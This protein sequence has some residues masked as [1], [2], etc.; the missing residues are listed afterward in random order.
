MTTGFLYM[1]YAM[2]LS[3]NGAGVYA[4]IQLLSNNVPYLFAGMRGGR[5]VLGVEKIQGGYAG[6][7]SAYTVSTGTA[8]VHTVVA[9]YD[10]SAR[11]LSLV[12]VY[13]T[14]SIAITE[15]GSWD[16]TYTVPAADAPALL[17]GIRL[18]MGGYGGATLGETWLDEIRL[19]RSWQELFRLDPPVATNYAVGAANE[20][21]DGA[22][23]GGTYGVALWLRDDAGL[24]N[25][26]TTPNVDI[27]T[28]GG[29][30]VVTDQTFAVRT[31]GDGDH[32]I[33]PHFTIK[34]S[35]GEVILASIVFTNRPADGGAT[36]YAPLGNDFV[37][38]TVNSGEIPLGVYT[39]YVTA[40][41]NDEDRTGD[42]FVTTSVA[43][44]TFTVIQGPIIHYT[45]GSTND[46]IGTA[47]SVVESSTLSSNE[48]IWRDRAFEQRTDAGLNVNNDLQEF[49]VAADLNNLYFL[50]RMQDVNNF[51]APYLAIT[52]DTDQSGADSDGAAVGSAGGGMSFNGDDADTGLGDGYHTNG[53]AAL[54]Y[55]ERQIIVHNIDG[56]GQRIELYQGTNWYAPA[57]T[58]AS[59]TMWNA[60]DEV[61]EFTIA[62]EALGLGGTVTARFTVA[63]YQNAQIWANDGDSTTN[64]S[65]S[66]ALDT[67]ALHAYGYNHG[68]LNQNAYDQDIS[69]GDLDFFF[70][71]R[72]GN[73]G[74]LG[75]QIPSTPGVT[76]PTNDATLEAG[77]YVTF[78]WDAATDAD[79]AVTS[80]LLEIGTNSTLGGENATVDYRYNIRGNTNAYTVTGLGS[81]SGT[82]FFWRVRSRDRAGA[83]SASSPIRAFYLDQTDDDT[84]VPVPTLLYVGTNYMPGVSGIKT[85]I[86]DAEAA[87]RLVPVDIAIQWDDPSG[88]F[89]TN[90]PPY[91]STNIYSAQGRIVPNWD[92]TEV[93]GTTTNTYGYDKPFTNFWGW[94]GAT[95]VTTYHH[96]AFSLTNIDLS[97]TYYL[98]VSAEDED[99]E[100][101][102]DP[103]GGGDGDAIPRDHAVATNALL[104]FYVVDDDPHPPTASNLLLSGVS[105]AETNL[106]DQEIRNGLWSLYLE[107]EDAYSGMETSEASGM[108]PRYSMVN[109]LGETVHQ[110]RTW[111]SLSAL[112]ASAIR[113]GG[114]RIMD[115]VPYTNVALGEYQVLWTAYDRDNDRTNDRASRVNY[116]GLADGTNVFTVVDDDTTPP[117]EITNVQY[118]VPGLVWTNVNYF[119]VRWTEA[120]DDSGVTEY[121]ASTNWLVEP[122]LI[123]DGFPLPSFAEARSQSL[124]NTSFG[125]A[126]SGT[127]LPYL[128]TNVYGWGSFSSP[129]ARPVY[130]NGVAQDGS[131][132]MCLLIAEGENPGF[133]PRYAMAGQD[134]W[135]Y[136]SNQLPVSLTYF[137]GY[138]R[139][140]LSATGYAG[141][142]G[143]AYL[144]VVFM[145]QY[146]NA[147]LTVDNEYDDDHNGAPL[148]GVNA[149]DWTYTSISYTNGPASTAFIRFMVGIAQHYSKLAYTG[150]WDS[151]G[152][153]ISFGYA[154]MSI[155][156]NAGE[157]VLTNWLFAVDSD[158][159]RPAD[160]LK[161]PN[162]NFVTMLDQTPPPQV[163]DLSATNGPDETSEALLEWTPLAHAGNRA[164]DDTPLSPWRSYVLFYEECTN[165]PVT[166]NS[167][168][169]DFTDGLTALNTNTTG[170]IVLSNLNYDAGYSVVIAGLDSAGNLGPLSATATVETVNFVVTQ[171]LTRAVTPAATSNQVE[172]AWLASERKVYDVLYT[173]SPKIT[174]FRSGNVGTNLAGEA[175]NVIYQTAS[176]GWQYSVGGSGSANGQL[177]PLDQAFL[178]ELPIGA[179]T[180]TLVVIAQVPTQAVVQAIAGGT[181]T[182]PQY[183]VL[184]VNFPQRTPISQAGIVG[185]GFVANNNH[186]LADEVRILNNR[187]GMGSLESPKAR[188][189]R[190]T[191]NTWRYN[192]QPTN[193]ACF[194]DGV[195]PSA[196][197]YLIEPDEAV[198]II[199]RNAGTMYW[200][201]RPTYTAPGKTMNP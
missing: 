88:V 166:T 181:R 86:T 150:Y 6:S 144:K 182:S 134:V 37:A 21:T 22:L 27:W 127:E 119:Q 51:G 169:L 52:V 125:W 180:Q 148:K 155:V 91:V 191:D 188:L 117:G 33:S 9:R 4:G 73:T 71:V 113:V 48:F 153:A 101:G 40:A 94:N 54:H 49:R 17:N 36:A 46:W 138:F 95:S 63:T 97:A 84:T 165:C 147:I 192:I 178:L 39:A 196:D 123:E 104:Q 151:V 124:T 7:D 106:T 163:A 132:S 184:S 197:N 105:S 137:G 3:A 164:S 183:H 20:V 200:T 74:L 31:F 156:T 15:P 173:D 26:T 129:G 130:T 10:F 131:M 34:N 118:V 136:N 99:N 112:D 152:T 114:E 162:T 45:D 96:A 2:N 135:L 13:K 80:Y 62:R 140:D 174:W 126:A 12:G 198:L 141:N 158:E 121:R 35:T 159:D 78:A 143:I 81:H 43:V 64:Y 146:S 41:D 122:T 199:R 56:V 171:G 85:N 29:I 14:G 57:V 1:S 128:P 154:D 93:I 44:A 65:G 160:Q 61:L 92:I 133:N 47:P 23:T 79:D 70:D 157:G 82:Q 25:S 100:R 90:H 108:L 98:T 83:L 194:V 167:T 190:R 50:V 16:V 76:G 28:A 161:G 42:R 58:G 111:T 149:A 55:G 75:N 66:D 60:T 110:G 8:N 120:E 186:I 18:N 177:M 68:T 103:D 187:N 142:V 30:Q 115:Q 145:D 176:S 168:R 24:T 185:S 175:T 195:I 109:S 116:G 69:D 5:T 172:V 67:I 32:N 102:A 193:T 59:N 189:Y 170:A 38:Q 139:G 72:L 19:A 77:S 179:P 201:N 11:T 53:N 87:N 89:L 107:M